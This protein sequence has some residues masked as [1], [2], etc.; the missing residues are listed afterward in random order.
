MTYY[1]AFSSAYR[2]PAG[3]RPMA[4]PEA[5]RLCREAAVR[6]RYKR[7][8]RRRAMQVLPEAARKVLFDYLLTDEA[9]DRDIL[10]AI[11]RDII[12]QSVAAKGRGT[13]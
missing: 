9:R 4:K 2:P 7:A 6:V 8:I 12:H 1:H 5:D 10:A 13:T 11:L 3:F